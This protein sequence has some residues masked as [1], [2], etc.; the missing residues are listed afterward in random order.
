MDRDT[1][2]NIIKVSATDMEGG[3]KDCLLYTDSFGGAPYASVVSNRQFEAMASV[4][5]GN[6]R[7]NFIDVL[8]TRPGG[9]NEIQL[10][11]IFIQ[12]Y[13]IGNF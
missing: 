6:G 10:N 2:R 8:P 1:R 12:R 13:C 3:R 4:L 5:D 11:L 9:T 7:G